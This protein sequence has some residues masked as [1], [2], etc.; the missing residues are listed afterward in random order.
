MYFNFY[1]FAHQSSYI[2][3]REL[4]FIQ[5]FFVTP[6]TFVPKSN[7]TSR[8]MTYSDKFITK[9]KFISTALVRI[10]S[11]GDRRFWILNLGNIRVN[12]NIT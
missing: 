6:D 3:C 2:L 4:L 1:I 10:R 7:K 11:N 12:L 8:L 5:G 9:S